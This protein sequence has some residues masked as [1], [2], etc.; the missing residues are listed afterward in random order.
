MICRTLVIT[1]TQLVAVVWTVEGLRRLV[2]EGPTWGGGRGL[3]SLGSWPVGPSVY[4]VLDPDKVARIRGP[5]K[6]ATSRAGPATAWWR[7]ASPKLT[8][9]VIP[10]PRLHAGRS[11]SRA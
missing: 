6:A 3:S 5:D 11:G 2:S 8:R 4:G 10:S 9:A 1:V 7:A